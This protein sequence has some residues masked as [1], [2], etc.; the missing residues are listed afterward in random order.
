MKKKQIDGRCWW[1]TG[2]HIQQRL[3]MIKNS[4]FAIFQMPVLGDLAWLWVMIGSD[5][6]ID[7]NCS[8]YKFVEFQ[9]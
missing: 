8:D 1:Y 4:T 9:V 2:R 5:D 6:P 7:W 3:K